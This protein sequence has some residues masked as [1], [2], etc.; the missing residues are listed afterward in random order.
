MGA[1][2]R[3]ST[4]AGMTIA[5]LSLFGAGCD[6]KSGELAD[7]ARRIAASS[8]DDATAA[9]V[10]P[11]LR[12]TLSHPGPG[13]KMLHRPDAAALVSGA[14]AGALSPDGVVA[15]LRV[16]PGDGDAASSTD[17]RVRAL[18][19]DDKQVVS[20][21]DRK[22]GAYDGV[23][24]EVTGVSAGVS[25]R[26]A[27]LVVVRGALVYE[28][29]AWA[30]AATPKRAFEPLWSALVLDEGEV[31]AGAGAAPTA[32][33]SDDVVGEHDALR[34]GTWRD[35]AHNITVTRPDDSW[36]MTPSS[37]PAE[38]LTMRR[39]GVTA[40]VGVAQGGELG[41]E[42]Y[43]KDAQ[44]R[45][46]SELGVESHGS[47]EGSL[48]GSAARIS[49]GQLRGAR[50]ARLATALH[51]EW[52]VT[53]RISSDAALTQDDIDA[54]AQAISLNPSLS[55]VDATTDVYR[56]HRLGYELRQPPG[57]LREDIT[58]PELAPLGSLVRW[59]LEG[60]WFAVAAVALHGGVERRAWM[61]RF[62]EQLLRDALSP[63]ARGAPIH[64]PTVV[65][66]RPAMRVRWTAPL[67]R[68]D[69]VV[70]SGDAVVYGLISIDHAEG[71][72]EALQSGFS[73]LP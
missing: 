17:A 30:S 8:K 5:W 50:R 73:L 58:P 29:I 49:F 44:D 25:L 2:M 24:F 38:L 33:R 22:V 20:R 15:A 56:D 46:R 63:D 67:M 51:G 18:A 10:D 70:V 11:A 62:L 47:S 21:S 3:R 66:N 36:S 65:S 45:M 27:G 60:R 42:H 14:V 59:Q 39:D 12:F 40:V 9:V 69:A 19:L 61:A 41:L 6:D 16:T 55:M 32:P 71:A 52:A 64:E 57:W 1:R 28:L 72:L 26:F 31:D 35:F 13:W 68:S 48:G 54:T 53:L 23:A 7:N 34:G 4:L 43:H 37:R